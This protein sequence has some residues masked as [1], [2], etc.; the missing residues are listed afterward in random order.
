MSINA[1][2]CIICGKTLR[3]AFEDAENQPEHGVAVTTPGNYGSTVFDPMDGNFLEFTVCDECLVRAGEQGRV[4]TARTERPVIL[5]GGW[6]V[7][8]ERTPYRPVPWTKDTP[9]LSDVLHIGIEDLDDLPRTVN[10]AGGPGTVTLTID[11]ETLT[12]LVKQIEE[13]ET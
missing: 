7:G 4:Y 5:E 9:L 8:T 10:R 11:D 6:F 12:L 3:N 2:P 1:L 13:T